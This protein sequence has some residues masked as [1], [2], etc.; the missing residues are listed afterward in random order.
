MPTRDEQASGSPDA[1]GAK[2]GLP[3]RLPVGRLRRAQPSAESPK[4]GI[5][6]PKGDLWVLA[7]RRGRC[8]GSDVGRHEGSWLRSPCR[9]RRETTGRQGGE[10]AES[11]CYRCA[12]AH[13]YYVRGARC[14]GARVLVRFY[15]PAAAPR[16]LEAPRGLFFPDLPAA[17]SVW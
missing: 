11:S 12:D 10:S 7:P 6:R 13:D 8:R 3:V 14:G 9:K 4:D 2:A 17:R 16:E 1:R 15:Q 5:G